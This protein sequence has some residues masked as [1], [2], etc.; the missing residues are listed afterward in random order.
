[1]KRIVTLFTLVLTILI[2]GS[3]CGSAETTNIGKNKG[4]LAPDFALQDINGNAVALEDFA[5]EKVY[6]KYWASWCSIC[7]AGLEDLDT[8]TAE[9]KDFKVISIVNPNFNAEKPAD[10]F[11]KWYERLEMENIIVLLDEDG[12]YAKQFRVIAYPTSYYIGTD[13]VLVKM[14]PGHNTN[15]Q[16]KKE[17]AKIE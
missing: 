1:M 3:G 9:E 16:I 5:G 8:L 15:E 13:G 14:I 12:T 10:K 17:M 2:I 6:V 7:L 4:D 11:I